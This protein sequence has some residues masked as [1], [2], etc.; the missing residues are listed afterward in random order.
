MNQQSF[1]NKEKRFVLTRQ[2]ENHTGVEFYRIQETENGKKAEGRFLRKE[3]F[4][5][6]KNVQ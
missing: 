2:Y 4:A 5:L 3:L 6:E 1:F